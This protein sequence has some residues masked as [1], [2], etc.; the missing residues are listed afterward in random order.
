MQTVV[1]YDRQTSSNGH[2]IIVYVN[3][4]CIDQ[5]NDCQSPSG[6]HKTIR[7]FFVKLSILDLYSKVNEINVSLNPDTV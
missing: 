7:D 1:P 4:S 3:Y 5:S 2:K 6:G